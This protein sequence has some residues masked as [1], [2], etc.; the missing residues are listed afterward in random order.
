[1][2][3]SAHHDHGVAFRQFGL[4]WL[5]DLLRLRAWRVS[6]VLFALR[7]SACQRHLVSGIYKGTRPHSECGEI[8][9]GVDK[10]GMPARFASH[11]ARGVSSQ[12][13]KD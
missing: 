13:P 11:V 7:F 9:D 8:V 5:A 10:G 3:N 6:C 2:E 12:T 1:L 4:G